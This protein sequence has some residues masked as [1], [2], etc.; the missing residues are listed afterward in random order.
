MGMKRRS[1]SEMYQV[2]F[3][4]ALFGAFLLLWISKAGNGVAQDDVRAGVI[5]FQG[6]CT[7]DGHQDRVPLLPLR[8]NVRCASDEVVEATRSWYP[9]DAC[10]ALPLDRTTSLQGMTGDNRDANQ[11]PAA[12]RRHG[13]PTSRASA[14]TAEVKF[15]DAKKEEISTFAFAGLAMSKSGVPT[16]E[17][18]VG[19]G[20]TVPPAFVSISV[21]DS[22]LLA[23][24]CTE[25]SATMS[26]CDGSRL[27]L[28]QGAAVNNHPGFDIRVQSGDW[29]ERCLEG[30]GLQTGGDLHPLSRCSP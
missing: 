30:V 22:A 11:L 14:M 17:V 15:Y 1:R 25:V 4:A 12:L 3:V 13:T 23:V 19:Y 8:D 10:D 29:P 6:W 28:Y 24:D 2:D 21:A 16:N 9:L 20:P 27:A 5:V 18:A 7:W 26:G